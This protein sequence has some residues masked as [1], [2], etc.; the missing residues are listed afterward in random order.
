[1]SSNG[2]VNQNINSVADNFNGGLVAGNDL[3]PA[4]VF[5]VAVCLSFTYQKGILTSIAGPSPPTSHL[6]TS[7]QETPIKDLR[8]CYCFLPPSFSFSYH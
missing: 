3:A 2:G 6:A 5:S 8:Q 7:Q 1:M 4:I